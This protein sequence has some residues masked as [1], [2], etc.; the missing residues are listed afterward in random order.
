MTLERAN[1]AFDVEVIVERG[2]HV[3]R[4]GIVF[5]GAEPAPAQ[6]IGKRARTFARPGEPR[7]IVVERSPVMDVEEVQP[8]GLRRGLL[9]NIA[10]EDHVAVRLRHL[11]AAEPHRRHVHPVPDESLAQ[12]VSRLALRDLAFVMRV[13]EIAT[14]AVNVDRKPKVPVGH[15]R[16]F[17]MPPRSAPP[18]WARPGRAFR[19]AA[20]QSE[21][22]GRSSARVVEPRVVLRRQDPPHLLRRVARELTETRERRDV[23]VK[24]T[25]RLVGVPAASQALREP[26]HR[27]NLSRRMRHHVRLPPAE[28]AHVPEKRALL[29]PSELA[30]TDLIPRGTLQDRLVEVG[31]VLGIADALPADLEKPREHVKNDER[32][33]VT[34]VCGVVRGHAADVHRRD[35]T[36]RMKS[37]GAAPPRVVE[38]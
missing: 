27:G 15:R 14:A 26:D 9:Q 24:P 30:P 6:E 20:P 22:E 28:A 10:H 19:H 4:R 12:P 18:E 2:E 13:E 38:P 29:T 21:V 11:R 37:E 7:L 31:D 5:D 32:A 35:A 33:G 23:V 16:T 3:V 34:Q 25:P 1:R 8:Q 36:A 17:E